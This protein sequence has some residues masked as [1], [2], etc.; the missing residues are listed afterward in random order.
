MI[1]HLV[2][3]L[4]PQRLMPNRTRTP[5]STPSSP[6][7]PVATA[8]KSRSARRPTVEGLGDDIGA[9]ELARR[10]AENLRRL[11]KE[12]QLSLDDLAL[13]SG[14][15]RAA[16]SQIESTRTN[17]TLGILWKVAAGLGVPFNALV[18]APENPNQSRV[19]R[20]GD[21]VALRSTDGRIESRLLSHAGAAD[22]IEVYELRFQVKGMLRSESHGPGAMEFMVVL[23]GSL[24]ITVGEEAHDLGPGDTLFFHANYAHSYE[25]M[26]SHECRC[27][28]IIGYGRG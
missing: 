5:R 9:A 17:P 4:S 23:T 25:N 14:V 1:I 6:A 11:R 21:A 19:L 26:S 24:R 2:P 22:R 28:N 7:A 3:V 18:G 10:V 13:R 15:S 16:L 8:V 27:I 12:K 20:S